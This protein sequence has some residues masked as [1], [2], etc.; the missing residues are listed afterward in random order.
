M[1]AE[2]MA[3]EV[4]VPAIRDTVF[5]ALHGGLNQL[6]YGDTRHRRGSTPPAYSN[7]GQVNY[8]G[9][10]SPTNSR[11]RAPAPRMLSRQSRAQQ[12]FDDIVIPTRTEAETVLDQMFEILSRYDMVTVAELYE[13][14]G[15]QSGHTDH[16]WGWT[17]LRGAK[18]SRLR[19]G[20]YLLELPEPEA[21]T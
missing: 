13:M 20:G 12:A 6:M 10:S 4:V 5:D 7:V 18:V 1:A 16:K 14:T 11:T 21:L 9:M 15:I 3:M 19:S 2:Y 17:N 8:Q